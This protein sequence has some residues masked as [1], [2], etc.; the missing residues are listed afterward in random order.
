MLVRDGPSSKVKKKYHPS[1]VED[2]HNWP[3]G[4]IWL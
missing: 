1:E 3:A 4:A 2:L